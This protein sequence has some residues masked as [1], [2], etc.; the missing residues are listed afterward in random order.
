MLVF[1]KC[2]IPCRCPGDQIVGNMLVT[3][4]GGQR[5]GTVKNV[6]YIDLSVTYPGSIRLLLRKL[7]DIFK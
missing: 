1:P 5:Y 2:L 4:T 7:S 6:F 3:E